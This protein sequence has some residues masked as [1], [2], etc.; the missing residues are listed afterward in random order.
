[1]STFALVGTV[2]SVL[3]V[4]VFFLVIIGFVVVARRNGAPTPQTVRPAIVPGQTFL[5]LSVKNWLLAV[6]L[7]LILI[8]GANWWFELEPLNWSWVTILAVALLVAAIA[9]GTYKDKSDPKGA[10]LLSNI[11]KG[12]AVAVAV[13]VL[14]IGPNKTAEVVREVRTSTTTMADDFVN[15]RLFEESVSTQTKQLVQPAP[16]TI[17]IPNPMTVIP[18]TNSKYDSSINCEQIT[19]NVINSQYARTENEDYCVGFDPQSGVN[20]IEDPGNPG[21]YLFTPKYLGA[22]VNVYYVAP[23]QRVAGWRC[24]PS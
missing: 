18:C 20:A 12:L 9:Y 5:G 21:V 15:D 23:G 6:T 16:V 14:L 1:M 17:V 24:D 10:I 13:M 7:L 3:F 11:A 2:V 8:I 4:V 19:F 22:Q